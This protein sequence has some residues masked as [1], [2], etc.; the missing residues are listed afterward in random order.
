MKEY[1][2]PGGHRLVCRRTEFV[3]WS[4]LPY[5]R[6]TYE[7]GRE[8]LFNRFYEAIWQRMPGQPPTPADPREHPGGM[9]AVWFYNDGHSEAQKRNRARAV[10]AEWKIADVPRAG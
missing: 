9:G 6:S 5:G 7:D 2:S 1:V 8:V 10:L 3:R 4:E